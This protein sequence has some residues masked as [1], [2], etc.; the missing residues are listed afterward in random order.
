MAQSIAQGSR[1]RIRARRNRLGLVHS[2]KGK[3]VSDEALERRH[4]QNRRNRAI[5]E[6]CIAVNELGQEYTLQ[7]LADLSVSNP[8]IRRPN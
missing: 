1:P 3:Y 7:Q 4:K 8:K 2:R 6:H 5:L